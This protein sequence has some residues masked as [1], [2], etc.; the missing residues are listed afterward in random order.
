MK[1]VAIYLLVAFTIIVFLPFSITNIG[2]GVKSYAIDEFKR[3]FDYGK[4]TVNVFNTNNKKVETMD[5]EEYVKGVVAAEMPI[6]F[7]EEALKAQAV[8]ARTYVLSRKNNTLNGLNSSHD[9]ADV[10][11]DIH[12]QAWAGKDALNTRWGSEAQINWVKIERAVNETEGL[13]ITYNKKLINPLYHSN[14]GGM[15]ENVVNVWGTE[16]VPYLKPVKSLGEETFTNEY[17][18]VLNISY[19]DF[20]NK[21]KT[22]YPNIKFTSKDIFKEI[23]IVSRTESERVKEIKVGNISIKGTEFRTLLG[24]KSAN[25][26][27]ERDGQNGIKITTIGSGHGVGMSQCG[28]DYMALHGSL[29]S[30]ILKYYYPST[31][32]IDYKKTSK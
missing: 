21:L 5:L 17:K 20:T 31:E 1:K 7:E 4:I 32:I 27:I 2:G 16:E 13:V 22:A 26:T 12:C 29:F 3:S 8:A 18:N 10:C 19:T 23:N 28:A 6:N 15:T 25:Y 14:S 24:L 9:N 30:D 11:T